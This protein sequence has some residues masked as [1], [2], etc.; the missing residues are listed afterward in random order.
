MTDS[1]F[2][3]G[4]AVRGPTNSDRQLVRHEPTLNVYADGEGESGEAYLSH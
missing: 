2:A 3:C 1:P 4:L